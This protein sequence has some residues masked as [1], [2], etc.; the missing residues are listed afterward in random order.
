MNVGWRDVP[1]GTILVLVHPRDED[2]NMFLSKRIV[3]LS[4]QG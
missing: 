2:M 3:N 4:R 1:F